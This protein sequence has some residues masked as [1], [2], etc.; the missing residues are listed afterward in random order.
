MEWFSQT[1]LVIQKLYLR[2]KNSRRA[3]VVLDM[4]RSKYY[5]LKWGPNTNST[6]V[7]G[8]MELCHPAILCRNR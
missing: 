7:K 3:R 4:G 2:T 8:R 5:W 6:L 1:T